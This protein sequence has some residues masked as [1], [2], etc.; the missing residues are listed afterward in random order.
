MADGNEL[1]W[2]I[3]TKLFFVPIRFWEPY[4]IE[5]GTVVEHDVCG[6][7]KPDLHTDRHVYVFHDG[8][9]HTVYMRRESS[10]L[11]RAEVDAQVEAL[12]AEKLA[13]EEAALDAFMARVFGSRDLREIN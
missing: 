4:E 3:G 6:E 8:Y 9:G 2:E 7:I 1:G 11:T 5:T 13:E 12:R 10:F